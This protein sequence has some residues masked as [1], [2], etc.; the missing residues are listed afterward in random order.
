MLPFKKNKVFNV[1]YTHIS[2]D[3]A[4][5]TIISLAKVKNGRKYVLTPNVQHVYLYHKN[6]RFRNSYDAAALS[7]VDG[8]PLVLTSKVLNNIE[9]E[10]VSGSDVFKTLLPRSIIENC[11]VFLLGGMPG[12]A[13]KAA[14]ILCGENEIGKKIICYSPSFGFEKAIVT[15][16]EIV[17]LINSAQ[18]DIL[19]LALGTPKGEIWVYENIHKINVGVAIQVG[20]SFDYIAGAQKRAPKIIQTI[21]LE[22][23]F[24]LIN[25]PKRLWKRYLI[26]NSFFV[27]LVIKSLFAKLKRNKR[28]L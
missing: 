4:L 2:F 15:N 10:K 12:I 1:P 17:E 3:D 5:E 7:L 13:E 25:D 28:S 14:K 21:G 20:A 19:F 27:F 6:K 18:P 16:N 22:W 26:T 23:F 11:K 8:F 24:R 9:I